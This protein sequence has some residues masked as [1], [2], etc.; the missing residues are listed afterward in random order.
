VHEG[1]AAAFSNSTAFGQTVP[2][3]IRIRVTDFPENLQ[4]FFP[5]T[6]TASSGAMLTTVEGF[7]V[8]LPRANGNP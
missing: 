4:M 8:T 2:T 6:V 3:R 5:A 7:A 1:Y